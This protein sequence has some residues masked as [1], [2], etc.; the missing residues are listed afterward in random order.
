M[1]M[2][3]PNV[4]GFKYVAIGLACFIVAMAVLR[5]L[6]RLDL[7]PGVSGAIMISVLVA[8]TAEARQADKRR[9]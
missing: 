7:A 8:S 9:A 3:K 4:R 6:G 1:A 5:T 2:S